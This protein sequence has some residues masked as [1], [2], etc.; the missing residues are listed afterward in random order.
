VDPHL[1]WGGRDIWCADGEINR[2][3]PL[4]LKTTKVCSF[5]KKRTK[6]LLSVG[7]RP[8]SGNS[9]QVVK[10]KEQKFF[11]SFFQKRRPSCLH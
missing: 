1:V 7:V 5:L 11:A 2:R 4:A 3:A 10:A 6:K 8:R 9:R